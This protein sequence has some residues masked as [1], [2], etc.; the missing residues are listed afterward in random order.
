MVQ[1]DERLASLR[2]KIAEA[3]KAV[4]DSEST[5]PVEKLSK[6]VPLIEAAMNKSKELPNT[7]KKNPNNYTVNKAA[8][9]LSYFNRN[10]RRRPRTPFKK[11]CA[12]LSPTP[13]V[14][15]TPRDS[16]SL[17]LTNYWLPEMR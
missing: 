13:S 3:K 2:N 1:F 5:S 8:P 10:K 6:L 11:L 7:V 12:R 17:L 9:T 15:E 16:S 14:R 4:E